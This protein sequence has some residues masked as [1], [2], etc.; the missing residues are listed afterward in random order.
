M[1]EHKQFWIIYYD[2][3][4]MVRRCK[5]CGQIDFRCEYWETPEK[6]HELVTALF[7]CRE[8]G[9]GTIDVH[10]SNSPLCLKPPVPAAP[11]NKQAT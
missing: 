1:C 7:G 2:G 4:I 5:E 3:S 10:S 9:T 6:V 11:E 8:F